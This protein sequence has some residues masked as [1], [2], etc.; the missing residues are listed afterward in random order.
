MTNPWAGWNVE[1]PTTK[2]RRTMLSKCGRKCFLGK[3]IS[4]P[5]CIKDTCT[6]SRKGLYAA[7]I[8]SRQ[9][10]R[11]SISKRAKKMLNFFSKKKFTQKKQLK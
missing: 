11:R 10:H 7:Y 4:Y 9:F 2:Q 5:I 6:I 8:R 3:K 1:R